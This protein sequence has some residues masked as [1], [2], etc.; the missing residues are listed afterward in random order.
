MAAQIFVH[1]VIPVQRPF[2]SEIIRAYPELNILAV[3][4]LPRFLGRV[5]AGLRR[6]PEHSN[7]A[8]FS[9]QT[10]LPVSRHPKR[11]IL[12]ASTPRCGS[13]FLGHMLRDHGGFGVPFEYLHQGNTLYWAK[14]FG[15][16][17]LDDLF[18]LFL[19]YR[20]SQNGT[21]VVKAHWF[22][23]EPVQDRIGNM[24]NGLGIA[25]TLWV[26]RE[27]LLSQA[28]SYVIAA[29]T[30]VWISGAKA[31]GEA[32]YDH[33]RIIAAA[34]EIRRQNAA[35][36]R[37]RATI[38]ADRFLTVSYEKILH[39]EPSETNALSD[40]LNLTKA[41][42]PS[43]R[44]A[45]QTGRVNEEWKARFK[46]EAGPAEQWIFEPQDWHSQTELA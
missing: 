20:T 18:P 11:I 23:F 19:R 13:H 7:P 43:E 16:R 25:K 30:G 44:T 35:W 33:D 14:R 3:F 10:D 21:F 8:Q 37:H 6:L 27:N 4:K 1:C 41:L 29:Q 45:R 34:N 38:A 39:R 2:S 22:Q 9:E 31:H 24:T 36:A 5:R 26:Y 40:F 28:I 15:T 32:S 46:S 17:N 42:K 12:I